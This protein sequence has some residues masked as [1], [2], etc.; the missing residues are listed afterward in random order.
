MPLI[1]PLS[2][3]TQ[4]FPSLFSTTHERVYYNRDFLCEAIPYLHLQFLRFTHSF[5]RRSISEFL[6]PNPTFRN[7]IPPIIHFFDFEIPPSRLR[8]RCPQ[9]L[10]SLRIITNHH[11]GSI[12]YSNWYAFLEP[13]QTR[14][15][16]GRSTW[17]WLH[18]IDK[19]AI[20]CDITKLIFLHCRTPSPSPSIVL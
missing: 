16:T 8:L 7:K 12:L 14:I 1:S 20:V 18:H 15:G 17:R 5:P 3:P 10:H 6:P 4:R 13:A 9:H 11:E 19:R 2:P